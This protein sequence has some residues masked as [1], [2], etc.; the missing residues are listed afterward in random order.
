[1]RR[2]RPAPKDAAPEPEEPRHR[3]AAAAGGRRH[4]RDGAGRGD[5]RGRLRPTG[6]RAR[7]TSSRA[8]EPPG[9][10]WTFTH[11]SLVVQFV[12]LSAIVSIAPWPLI[13]NSMSSFT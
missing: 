12:V 13:Q 5:R 8:P 7:L 2:L 1:G 11:Q 4:R 9:R 6:E 3:S 10:P